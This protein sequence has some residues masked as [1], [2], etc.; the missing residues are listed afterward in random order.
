[1]AL[2]PAS[3]QG[4]RSLLSFYE[5]L[6]KHHPHWEP[7]ARMMLELLPELELRLSTRDAWGLT[8][9]ARLV[10]LPSDE[11]RQPYYVVIEALELE[12]R[13]RITYAMDTKDAP[14]ENATVTGD[15]CTA[16]EAASM[17]EVAM[18]RCGA[19]RTNNG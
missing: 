1:M 16:H 4:G 7:T 19:W 12:H 6:S 17:V 10:L 18:E 14:W 15:A 11:Y 8:S 3:D 13:F 5:E 2:I 9:H